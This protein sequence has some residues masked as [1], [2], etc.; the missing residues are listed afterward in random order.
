[1]KVI[2]N[3]LAIIMLLH[4]N[5]EAKDHG[6]T[7]IKALFNQNYTTQQKKELT[8]IFQKRFEQCTGQTVNTELKGDTLIINFQS[9]I[10]STICKSLLT[11]QGKLLI[12]ET[13]PKDKIIES[14]KKIHAQWEINKRNEAK[15]PV[16]SADFESE[17]EPEITIA[18][19]DAATTET[20]LY[21]FGA[22][23]I[24]NQ[25]YYANFAEIG[26]A[27]KRDTAL[28]NNILKNESAKKHLPN[29]VKF[30]WSAQAISHNSNY[31]SLYA[32][33]TVPKKGIEY[34]N[35]SMI[36]KAKSTKSYHN[37]WEV[38]ISLKPEYHKIW[39]DLTK[40]NIGMPLLMIIDNKVIMSP[41]VNMAIS[42]GEFVISQAYNAQSFDNT[43]TL[44]SILNNVLPYNAEI[45]IFSITQH[46]APMHYL[47]KVF[48]K[49][50]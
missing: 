44:T 7:Q 29:N 1:M 12:A 42:G 10:D 24:N 22:L 5:A 3:I 11:T 37:Y 18:I 20:S 23:D 2:L 25:G 50:I 39:E 26:S 41:T 9:V 15:T 33:K 17:E 43:K 30:L 35:N 47:K 13:Y 48:N 4:T 28:I 14:L 31:Y 49:L 6:A 21:L 34:I 27:N 40:E 45:T 19:A 8:S 38:Q 36:S 46:Y 16:I 32:I